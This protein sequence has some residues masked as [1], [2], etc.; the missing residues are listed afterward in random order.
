MSPQL[1]APPALRPGDTIAVVAPAGP[2]PLE[3][4]GPG[5]RR[6]EKHYKL[7]VSPD[8]HRCENF[9]A[10]SDARRTEEFNAAVQNPDVRAIWAA[11]GGYGCSRIVDDLDAAAFVADPVPIVGFSDVTVLL[12]WAA[13]HGVRSIHGPVLTQL[14][15]LCEG[16][17]SWVLELLAGKGIGTVLPCVGDGA[18]RHGRLIGGNLSLLAHSCG[19][20][21]APDLRDAICILEDVGERPYALDRYLT[22]LL[23][24]KNGI[25]LSEATAVILGDFTLCQETSDSE[26]N[27]V[28]VVQER[29]RTAGLACGAGLSVGHGEQNRA[30]PFGAQAQLEADGLRLLEPATRA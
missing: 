12:C 8:I 21:W 6:L 3:R 23:A 28:A 11:R 27:P 30:F 20:T 29:L 7:L 10:G 25:V 15:E 5:L 13:K 16:D 18:P 24:Q 4:L 9:L 2:V 17:V 19:T 1:I 22:Q 26:L 14:G